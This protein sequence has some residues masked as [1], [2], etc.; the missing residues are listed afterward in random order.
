MN[1]FPK[2]NY[3]YYSREEKKEDNFNRNDNS[4]SNLQM[5]GIISDLKKKGYNN[6]QIKDIISSIQKNNNIQ[7]NNV[8][9]YNSINHGSRII[10]IKR[11][12]DHK[13]KGDNNSKKENEKKQRN[14]YNKYNTKI[15]ISKNISGN[16]CN[17]FNDIILKRK[18]SEKI[19]N[20][21]N[22]PLL[23]INNDRII[24]RKKTNNH[25]INILYDYGNIIK[26]Q[27]LNSPFNESRNKFNNYSFYNSKEK[28]SPQ[29][30]IKNN[31]NGNKNHS[32]NKERRVLKYK[33]RK[34]KKL[35][36]SDNNIINKSN[37]NQMR[38][39][40][41]NSSIKEYSSSK[42]QPNTIDNLENKKNICNKI[43]E[44]E[45]NKLI[46]R[47][48]SVRQFKHNLGFNNIKLNYNAI[49][50]N[51]K[52]E[53]KIII[54]EYKNQNYKYNNKEKYNN[55]IYHD[56]SNDI[57]N[58]SNNSS[59]KYFLK[60]YDSN[61]FIRKIN[62][63]TDYLNKETNIVESSLNNE[64][65]SINKLKSIQID[66]NIKLV[67]KKPTYNNLSK[68]IIYDLNNNNPKISY[69]SHNT[70]NSL[71]IQHNTI[72]IEIEPSYHKKTCTNNNLIKY[73]KVNLK[74][75][76]NSEQNHQST[77]YKI[78]SLNQINYISR[79]K[80]YKDGQF[81]GIIINGKRELRGIMKYKNGGKYEG[82]WKND[83]RNGK[84]VFI[85]Q[86]YNNP[87][88][89]G[90]KYEGEFNN[91]KIEGYGIGKYSSGDKYEG[92]WK[93]NKQ[94]GRGVLNYVGGGK[95][96]GEWKNGK[97]NGEGTY[98]LKNGERFEGKF[99]DNK[100]NGYGKYYYNNGEYLE[101]I[102]HEDL[103]TGECIL[104]KLDGTT[105]IKNYN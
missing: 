7:N 70:I 39:N 66:K 95:Y 102:F 31:V 53:N 10:R 21:Y 81:E 54:C 13:T 11:G 35:K 77:K 29:K 69:N 12:Q 68:R 73:K 101:G 3:N 8:G 19:N 28:K 100:Y 43:I 2:N 57:K 14:E 34:P 48:R 16:K 87:N 20:F 6:H 85:S 83:K 18:T 42:N 33:N 79:R 56:I 49:N 94:Y 103:P 23:L 41:N 65:E 15:Y 17:Q 5:E 88:L 78:E 67:K 91:D 62:R 76:N 51:I 40:N 46:N 55:Y 24:P 60:H 26:R 22:K 75:R 99:E 71:N 50:N 4:F 30:G 1:K 32:N 9:N 27:K 37:S 80:R 105:E 38:I 93:N 25:I 92:E 58:I 97:L 47:Q 90:I 104:H 59:K 63:I 44:I 36:Q 45:Q 52:N 96:V 84:G 64:N 72:N 86:N 74:E 98:Y 89:T 61:A 82:Q